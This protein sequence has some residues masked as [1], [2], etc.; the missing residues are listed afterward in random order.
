MTLV[1][2]ALATMPELPVYLQRTLPGN[3]SRLMARIDTQYA[4]ADLLGRLDPVRSSTTY[5]DLIPAVYATI[6]LERI[7]SPVAGPAL[8]TLAASPIAS[9]LSL[10]KVDDVARRASQEFEPVAP[11]ALVEMLRR[12]LEVEAGQAT[13]RVHRNKEQ[14]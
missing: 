10:M 6:L 3:A 14:P 1:Q 13:G 11:D 4:A 8:S 2:E 12:A 9:Y 7:G 5:V